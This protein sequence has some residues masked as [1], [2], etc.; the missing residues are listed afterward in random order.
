LRWIL[1][2]LSLLFRCL[3]RRLAHATGAVLGWIWYYLIPVRRSVAR[4]NLRQAFPDKSSRERR[5]I[6]RDCFVHLARSAV[7]FLRLPGL[8]RK[9]V[10]KLIE[11]AGWENYQQAMEKG[12]GVIVVTAHFGNFDLL[13]CAQAI[14]G[15]PLHILTR[16]QHVDGF[17]RYW[18]S[19]RAKLGVG[20][21]PVKNS[22][23]RIHRL[24][25]KGQV[26]AMVIDQHMPKGRGVVVPFFNRPASTIH[27]PALLSIT[28]GALLLPVTIERLPGGRHRVT[29]EPPV[30][31][32]ETRDRD[33]EILRVTG[34][35][36]RWLENKIR[37]RPDHWLWIHRRW[38]IPD[39]QPSR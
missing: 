39:H 5:K 29:F 12:R 9:K 6:A 10:N 21:L 24:L 36:N 28:T 33:A 38:K 16:E 27:A 3:P 8:N 15:V 20:L 14:R 32:D 25:K 35:L 19:V 34:E 13:A 26:V 37:I 1:A 22:A 31:V 2:F 7:E 4:A 11:H 17:N 30:E 23:L 18:M